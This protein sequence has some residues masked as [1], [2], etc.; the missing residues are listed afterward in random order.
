MDSWTDCG[1]HEERKA[2]EEQVRAALKHLGRQ[3][4]KREAANA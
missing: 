4:Q 3:Q 2:R 1:T